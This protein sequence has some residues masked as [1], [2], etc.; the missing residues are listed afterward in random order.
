VKAS[1]VI[2]AGGQGKRFGSDIPKQYLPLGSGTVIEQ[3]I[4]RFTGTRVFS[5]LILVVHPDYHPLVSSLMEKSFPQ[6]GFSLVPSGKERMHSVANGLEEALKD[7][8]KILIHDAA[9]PFI[10]PED[11]LNCLSEL[12]RWEAVVV[13]VAPRDTVRSAGPDGTSS[14]TLDRSR[15]FLAQTPQGFTRKAASAVLAKIRQS[16]EIGTDDV[17][18][19]EQAGIPVRL[20]PGSSLNFKITTPEDLALAGV[21]MEHYESVFPQNRHRV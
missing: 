4:A 13:G 1:V 20:I 15:L 19:A 6:T 8:D 12:D 2:V 16:D 3:T 5:R 10:Q 21:I 9:R 11:I 14:G 18:F 7:S 17:Y